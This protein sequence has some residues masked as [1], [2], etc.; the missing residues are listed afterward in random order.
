ME[1]DLTVFRVEVWSPRDMAGQNFLFREVVH[2]PARDADVAL[3][4]DYRLTAG[5]VQ[6]SKELASAR[7][8]E[9]LCRAQT[10]SIDLMCSIAMTGHVLRTKEFQETGRC[11]AH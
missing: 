7:Q 11:C 5:F 4:E 10:R 3:V 1:H 6:C 2:I 8:C 9:C